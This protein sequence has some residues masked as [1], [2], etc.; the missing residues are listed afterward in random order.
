MNEKRQT[1]RLHIFGD[2]DSSRPLITFAEF[3]QSRAVERIRLNKQRI[4]ELSDQIRNLHLFVE[5][6]SPN[7]EISTLKALGEQLCSLI[8][9]KKVRSLFDIATGQNPKLLPLEIFVEDPAITGWPWE[10]LY[11]S[12]QQKFLSQEFHPISRGIFTIYSRPDFRPIK[13][14][15]RILL[16]TGVLPDDS[17]TTPQDEI[18]WIEEVFNAQLATDSVEIKVMQAVRPEDIDVELQKHSYD[19]LHYFGHARF[20]DLREEGYL[21]LAQQNAEPFNFYANDF[22]IM[23]ANKNIRLVFLNACETGRTSKNED[24]ARSSIAAALMA[25]GIP[26]VIATQFSIPDVTAHYLSSMTYNSLVTG[27]PLIEAMRNGRRAMGYS[28]KSKITDWGIPV[29]YTSDPDLIIFPKSEGDT[30]QMWSD[31]YNKALQSDNLLKALETSNTPDSPSVTVERTAIPANKE[32]AKM[33]VALI[34][35]DAKVGF[36]P[37]LIEQANKAQHYYNFEVNYIPL[38]SGSIRTDFVEQDGE[39]AFPQLYL[40]V[41]EDYIMTIPEDLNVDK[42][43]GLTRCRIAGTDPKT[44]PFQDY[45]ASALNNSEDVMAISVYKLKDYAKQSSIS[46]AKAI[47][48]VCL[49]M[50]VATDKR[51]PKMIHAETAGCLF[52][53]CQNRDDIVVGLK[54]MKFEHDKCCSKIKDQEQLVAI[55]ALLALD[56]GSDKTKG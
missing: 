41:I 16:I 32:A 22:A 38:P 26:A 36:L 50:V 15:V 33:R 42:V 5:T 55:D 1:F 44:G 2:L 13:N 20:D 4:D 49:G 7:F 10:Y 54:K 21:K 40:P 19:I 8:L 30:L 29:L 34:D 27:L 11:D 47:L 3:N 12:N 18:K 43:C 51:L 56:V 35:F 28:P 25:R 52:D 46:Y 39:A 48:Y 45:R 23:V 14:K 31:D 37:D 53:D 24:P 17:K 6:S 9:Q